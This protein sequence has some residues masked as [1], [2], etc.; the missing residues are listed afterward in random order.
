MKFA[1]SMVLKPKRITDL[2]A[3]S[4]GGFEKARSFKSL[5]ASML[6]DAHY[7]FCPREVAINLAASLLPADKWIEPAMRVAFQQ[8]TS[9]HDLFRNQWMRDRVVGQWECATCGYVLAFQK[10]PKF[11]CTCGSHRWQY[12]EEE[13]TSQTYGFSGS[14]D[15]LVEL[16]DERLTVV[17]L[18]S[19]DKDEFT[20]LKAPKA[21]HRIRTILYLYLVRDSG[22]PEVERINTETAKI[23]YI[24]KGYGK[25]D[26]PSGKVLPFKEYD[27]TYSSS[28]IDVYLKKALQV[29]QFR[30]E[31]VIPSGICTNSFSQRSK[32]CSCSKLC[33]SDKYPAMEAV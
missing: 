9:L 29:K 22:R 15:S 13:F 12:R 14:I 25:K 10:S 4:L 21:E 24:C 23:L 26:V 30:E 28:A 7:Q 1:K 6:T 2:L 31:N 11:S 32:M 27:V 19:I 20:D 8:G 5:R 33:W 17:E 3:D 16:G 18:K